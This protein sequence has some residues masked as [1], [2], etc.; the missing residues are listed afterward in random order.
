MI[1]GID[2]DTVR[3][4]PEGFCLNYF[5]QPMYIP[6]DFV[7]LSLGNRFG[8]WKIENEQEALV[9]AKNAFDIHLSDISD[10]ETII[11]RT[12]KGWLPYWGQGC[13][14]PKFFAYS[15][16]AIQKK[17]EALKYLNKI[18]AFNQHESPE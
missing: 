14:K 11:K 5:I 10:I 15:Y 3:F 17:P 2:V 6:S 16:L 1:L 12:L 8:E 9:A 18:I 13:S 7:C 4:V